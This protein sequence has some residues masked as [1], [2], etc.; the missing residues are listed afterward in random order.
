[1]I[2]KVGDHLDK[3]IVVAKGSINMY[4][5][6]EHRGEHLKMLIKRLPKKSW[7]GDS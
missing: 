5:F 3:L 7:F 6:Y 2:C 4:G 1:M